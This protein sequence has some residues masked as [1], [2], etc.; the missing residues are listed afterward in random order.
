MRALKIIAIAAVALAAAK[1]IAVMCW[2]PY[3]C[4]IVKYDAQ[5]MLFSIYDMP[6]TFRIIT[7]TRSRIPPL[8]ECLQVSP[9]DADMYMTVAALHRIMGRFDDAMEM[10][11]SALRF[12][13]RPELYLNLGLMQLESGD[14]EQAMPNLT[15]A[16]LFNVDFI[17]EIPNLDDRRAVLMM[18]QTAQRPSSAK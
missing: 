6:R 5:R 15:K 11:R 17:N 16:C 4:D 3:R 7:L 9:T 12:E 2:A 10:Y 1:A 18:V 14:R 13:Q 8:Q